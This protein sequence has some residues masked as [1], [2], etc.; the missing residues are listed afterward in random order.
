M[1]PIVFIL[2]IPVVALLT[3][4]VW[5]P[6][7]G[8]GI[9][10]EIAAFGWLG[11]IAAIAVFFG[12][13]ALYVRAL[14]ALLAQVRAPNRIR[15]P[16]SLWLMFAIPFNFVEDFFIIAEVA[17]SVRAEGAVAERRLVIWRWLGLGWCALQIVSLVPGETGV[18][19]GVLALVAWAAHWVLTAQTTR[20]LRRNSRLAPRAA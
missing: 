17:R 18:L 6:Q 14:Q 8:A 19:A 16:R 5:A 2:T 10:G 7:W 3:Q 12:L 4:P 20:A 11:G 9:L 13:V 15:S 1:R